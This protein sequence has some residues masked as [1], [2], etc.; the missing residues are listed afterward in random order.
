M[1]ELSGQAELAADYYR[2]TIAGEPCLISSNFFDRDRVDLSDFSGSD[3]FSTGSEVNDRVKLGWYYFCSGQ[4]GIA[5]E[6]FTAAI[7]SNPTHPSARSGLALIS[8]ESHNYREA[9]AHSAIA[10]YANPGLLISQYSAGKVAFEEGNDEAGAAHFDNALA[11]LRNQNY[12]ENYYNVV[13]RGPYL[14]HDMVPQIESIFISEQIVNDFLDYA[15][16][17][18]PVDPEKASDITALLTFWIPGN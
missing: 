15:E 2:R 8:L 7:G 10:L 9:Q 14:K 13:Y 4:V 5:R 17:L 18:N 16:T 3:I 1:L 12:S 6:E 11:I